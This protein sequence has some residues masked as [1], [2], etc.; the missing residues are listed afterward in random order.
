MFCFPRN[1]FL[2]DIITILNVVL[3][4]TRAVFVKGQF[5]KRPRSTTILHIHA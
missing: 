3:K 4:I 5:I 1:K 2:I